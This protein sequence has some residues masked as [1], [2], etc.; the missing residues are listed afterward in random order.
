MSKGAG[1]QGSRGAGEQ[2]SYNTSTPLHP[3]TATQTRWGWQDWSILLA[4]AIL[5]L[6]FHWRLITPDLAD[7][8]S[9]PP[10]DFSQ[11]F[12]AFSTFEARALSTGRLPLWNPYAFA[13]SPFWADVQSAVF[14]PFSLL[15]VLLSG[16]TVDGFSLFALQLEAILHFWLAG[17]F[18]YLFARRITRNRPAGLIAALTFTFGGYLTGYPSQQL[19]VLEVDVWLP[20]ILFFIDRALLIRN[21][22]PIPRPAPHLSD[23]ILA[24]A[25]WG[26]AILAGHPQSWMLVGYTLCAYFLYLRFTIYDLRLGNIQAWFKGG[27]DLMTILLIGLALAAVQLLP[28]IEYTRLSVRAEGVY[29][30]MAGGFPL[31]DPIQALL[32][33]VVSYYSPLYIGVV[34]LLLVVVAL[35]FGRNRFTVFWA[36]WG[37]LAFLISFGGETFLYT[38]LYLLGPGFS[39]FRGQERWAFVVAFSL[40]V[41]TGYGLQTLLRRQDNVLPRLNHLLNW[42]SLG[43]IGLVFLFFFGLNE[44]GWTS[45][46]RFYSLLNAAVLLVI[47]LALT[48][49]LIRVASNRPL[50]AGLLIGGVSFLVLF[51]LFTV[52]WQ[53]NLF[54][55][56]PE[57]HTQKPALVAAIEADMAAN[58][59]PYRVYNEFRLYDNYGIPFAQQDLWGASPLRLA[60]YDAFISPPMLI[61]RAWAMLNVKYVITWRSE[62]YVPSTILYQEA[63]ADGAT[64]L[65]RLESVGPRAWVV[66]QVEQ[67][68][69]SDMVARL[70]APDFD[71]FQIALLDPTSSLPALQPEGQDSVRL[72]SF[73]SAHVVFEV[74]AKSDGL[75]VFSEIDYPGWRA[76]IDDRPASIIR[77]NSALRALPVS[78]GSHV[79][80]LVFRPE[81]FRLGAIISSLTAGG[82]AFILAVHI[83]R[84]SR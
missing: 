54:P 16:L 25:A 48:K 57:Q 18:M 80:N 35:I 49:V 59:Q 81:S 78:S 5:V 39:I 20:L 61:E 4:L 22:Q 47:L 44:T 77:A 36:G 24:G 21:P 1:E 11:Q 68:P 75:L 60:T 14:Y 13:G 31:H 53:N 12:W 43:A 56:L 3:Y 29:D 50:S 28:A 51:D 23:L 17:F 63:A 55:A 19:A 9:Y 42:L 72:V 67:L 76:Y 41:L 83:Y 26:M 65:H 45:E 73:S 10:G 64:Y 82:L 27:L 37:G 46:N 69:A 70:A 15:T 38:P 8:Q 62:L 66:H 33:G 52:N 58:D 71:P 34:G 79:I 7:R 6:L 30:T 84:R 32:P 40:A 74:D 2:G